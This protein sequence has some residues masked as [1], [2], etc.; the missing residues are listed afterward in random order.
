MKATPR[1]PGKSTYIA[2]LRGINVGG[3]NIVKM[4][5]LR[6]VFEAMGLE[7]VKTYIQSGNIAFTAPVQ[8]SENLS[9]KIEEK[10]LRQFGMSITVIVRTSVELAE[11]I[12]N[13]PFP[14]EADL[15]PSKVF[16]IFLSHAP[17]KAALKKLDAIPA[18]PD[19]FRSCGKEVYVYCQN[20]YAETKLSSNAME[21]MLSVR[22]TARNW[23]TVNRLHEMALGS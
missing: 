9:A 19:K 14:K 1:P 5:H 23:R 4:D 16:V 3:H 21:K 6:K 2:L 20:G 15:D 8:V 13:N 17:K 18:G 12:T 10:L 22:S 7:D 11:A